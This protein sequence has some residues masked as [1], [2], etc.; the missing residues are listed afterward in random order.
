IDV[1]GDAS[2]NVVYLQV[3]D[4]T[5]EIFHYRL[6][7]V[8]FSGW[9]TLSVEPGR[10]APATTLAG[11]LDGRLDLP[12]SLYKVVLNKNTGGTKTVSVSDIVVDNLVYEYENATRLGTA[13]QVFVPAAG[14]TTS[15]RV[16][17]GEA[18]SIVAMLTDEAGR[19]RTFSG[20]AAGGGVLKSWTWNGRSDAGTLM[21]G[22]V[23]GRLSITRGGTTWTYGT[24]YLAGLPA[25]YE[26]AI[27]GSIVGINSAL[28]TINTVERAKAESQARLM[29]GAWIRMARESFDWNRLETRKGWYEWAK[30]DQAVEVARAHNVSLV[31][32]LEYSALWAS[33]APAGTT[34]AD[35]PYYP[36]ARTADYVDY[37]EAVVSRYRDRVHTWEIWNEENSAGFWK[38][39]PSASA[40]ASL[41][42][43]AYA[44][45]KAL[46]PTATVLL[47]GTVGFDRTF[48]DGLVA[49]GAWGSFDALAIHTYVAPQPET[50][51]IVTWLDNARAYVATKGAK[52]IWIT[53]FGWSTYAGSGGSYIGVSEAKQA[54]Y[55]A[56]AYLHAARVGVRG[57]FAYSLVEY[58]SSSTSKLDNYGLVEI[59]G[60]QK[61]AYAALRRVAE[62]LDGGTTAG[63]ADPNAASRVTVDGMNSANGWKLKPLGGGSASLT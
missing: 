5:G 39:A 3:R 33:S 52:P 6:G 21:T 59:G 30:F 32:R 13:S 34:T 37:V 43:A 19:V 51:M 8:S 49:A 22:S 42:K 1:H 62:A 9:S 55:T 16:G 50:S 12:I 60:R 17:P 26:P 31:G 29:E 63:L 41:L 10:S 45:I 56:R 28:T 58:G 15:V 18:G 54:D 23:R 36:P 35:K 20:S 7:N 53:E 57:V 4:A 38:P 61:P 46:D 2:W 47:G 40:Y 14:Q 44:K 11:N 25:R 27:P 24:P 48:L